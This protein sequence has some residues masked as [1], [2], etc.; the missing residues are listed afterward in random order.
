MA[1]TVKMIRE[2]DGREA[3]VHPDM[4]EEYKAGGFA[5]VKPRPVAKPRGAKRGGGNA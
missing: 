3:D 5:E 2:E 1:K 4:V